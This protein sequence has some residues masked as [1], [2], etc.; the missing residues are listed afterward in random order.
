MLC[1]DCPSDYVGAL[2]MEIAKLM[3]ERA[4]RRHMLPCLSLRQRAHL[5]AL[6]CQ[7][8][9]G[10]APSD[11]E[12]PVPNEKEKVNETT[13]KQLAPMESSPAGQPKLPQQPL[14]WYHFTTRFYYAAWVALRGKMTPQLAG[15]ALCTEFLYLLKVHNIPA[16]LPLMEAASNTARAKAKAFNFDKREKGNAGGGTIN[17]NKGSSEGFYVRGL[18]GDPVVIA[19]LWFCRAQ[20]IPCEVDFEPLSSELPQGEEDLFL[21]KSLSQNTVV[22][23]PLAAFVLCVELYL[24]QGG[25]WLG[26]LPP[27]S[28]SSLHTTRAIRKSAW[29]EYMHHILVDLRDPLLRFMR[30]VTCQERNCVKSQ[31]SELSLPRS[32]SQADASRGNSTEVFRRRIREMSD[33]AMKSLAHYERFA[34]HYYATIPQATVS[35]ADLCV[36]AYSFVIC[37][38]SLCKDFFPL[39]EAVPSALGKIG[40]HA[41]VPWGHRVSLYRD[42]ESK[43]PVAESLQDTTALLSGVPRAYQEIATRI[44]HSATSAHSPSVKVRVCENDGHNEMTDKGTKK[45]AFLTSGLLCLESAWNGLAPGAN[46]AAMF[47]VDRWIWITCCPHRR[48]LAEVLS[49]AWCTANEQCIG[50]PFLVIDGEQRDF[51]TTHNAHPTS[52]ARHEAPWKEGKAAAVVRS[53]RLKL[54]TALGTS[55]PSSERRTYRSYAAKL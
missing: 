55:P 6:R 24:P 22:T 12:L 26:E 45:L 7:A 27:F 3:E 1:R 35:V 34:H 19:F 39:L 49:Y 37:T 30:E 40:V 8:L 16:M 50:F 28:S 33:V 10:D 25:H 44:L 53:C 20:S 31:V 17:K 51:V 18:H 21:V 15:E 11:L 47:V 52:L 9:F 42:G 41:A 2:A 46:E 5:W 43:E 48:S 54:R 38:S 23:E 29:I 32:S 13:K 4:Y 14:H 36:A